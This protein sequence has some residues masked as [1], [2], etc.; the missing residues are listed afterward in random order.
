LKKNFYKLLGVD[1]KADPKKI[2]GAYRKAAKRYHPDISPKS[3]EKFKEI[4]EA[5]ETLSDPEK[6]AL[7][8]QENSKKSA[9]DIR[10]YPPRYSTP[11]FSPFN[12]F[13]DMDELFARFERS[14]NNETDAFL[15]GRGKVQNDFYVEI[16]LSPEE[17][18][19]GCELLLKIP[20]WLICRRCKGIGSVR[21][22]ICGLCRG[23]GEQRVE[24]KIKITI[25]SGVKEGREIKIP[26]KDLDVNR[27]YNIIVTLKIY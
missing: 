13:N 9:L 2:K 15:S 3:E 8:D 17:A 22:L 11:I 20:L 27:A 25:P 16:L 24:K 1:R 12:L 4:Q 14:W 23:R 21:D 19:N 6:K 18:M 5:Y 26:L 7:Y 10:P